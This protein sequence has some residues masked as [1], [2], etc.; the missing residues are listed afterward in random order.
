MALYVLATKLS[1]LKEDALLAQLVPHQHLM[2]EA[3]ELI[4]PHP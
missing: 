1:A 4:K 3:A 2:E